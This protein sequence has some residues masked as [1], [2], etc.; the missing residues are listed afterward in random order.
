M[1]TRKEEFTSPNEALAT[2]LKMAVAL[3]GSDHGCIVAR[4]VYD[5]TCTQVLGE[6]LPDGWLGHKMRASLLQAEPC[7]T[8]ANNPHLSEVLEPY[9]HFSS[10]PLSNGKQKVRAY[11]CL[12]GKSDT[13]VKPASEIRIEQ[14]VS[15]LAYEYGVMGKE[16]RLIR[17][18]DEINKSMDLLNSRLLEAQATAKIGSWDW[19]VET[20]ELF[21][22]DELYRIYGLDPQEGKISYELWQSLMH[23]EDA[24]YVNRIVGESLGSG[25]PFE[26]DH[27]IIR[28]DGTVIWLNG[29]GKASRNEAGNVIRMNGTALDITERKNAEMLHQKH[30]DSLELMM[31]MA[32]HKIRKP[33]T[34]ILNI[35]NALSEGKV[36]ND[37]LRQ[38]TGFFLEAA[39]QLDQFTKEIVSFIDH[40][41]NDYTQK[42][43]S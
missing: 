13:P 25:Q 40:H 8:A 37:D 10:Y 43:A 6:P 1:G 39:R 21:W 42:R 24:Q 19:N 4:S 3:T 33:V 31:Y 2:I 41:Q 16:K 14:V 7:C 32:S 17:Q 22:T 27:R 34:T 23:P 36:P 38:Y 5:W 35:H 28:P 20:G 15:L 29:R 18:L 9:G 30:Y 26:F 12:Y 11:L